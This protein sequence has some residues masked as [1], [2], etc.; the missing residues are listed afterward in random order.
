M[1]EA[2]GGQLALMGNPC[3]MVAAQEAAGKLSLRCAQVQLPQQLRWDIVKSHLWWQS[4]QRSEN[5]CL[6][7]IHHKSSLGSLLF[8]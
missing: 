2:R 3:G 6:L 7:G 4:I 1:L 5:K 8:D